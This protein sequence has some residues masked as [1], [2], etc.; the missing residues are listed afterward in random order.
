M[1]SLPLP[2]ALARSVAEEGSPERTEWVSRLP[3]IVGGLVERWALD[4]GA[5]FQPGG[6]VSWV[7]PARDAAGRD[8]VLKVGWTHEEGRDE[9]AGLRVWAGR[10]AVRVFE[11]HVD[12]PTTALLL[13]RCEPGTTCKNAL[14]EPEQ[15]GVVAGLLRRLWREPPPGHPFR[16]LAGMCDWWA[17]EFEADLA[18][19]PDALDPGLARAGVE[20]F[21]GLPR[22]DVPHRLLVTDLHAENVLAAQ[23]EPWLIIDPKPYVGDPAYDVLQHVLNCRDRLLADPRALAGR[24]ADLAGL[25]GER[26]Q[27]WLFARVVQESMNM[28]WLRE[29]V[30]RLAPR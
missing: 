16:T 20:L 28:P 11:T 2:T 8:V 22:E 10:G 18:A 9:A 12:G 3:E 26:V 29:V 19:E 23:R 24:M 4:V 15:D 25:D 6:Q 13:E 30:P 17:D 5:P 7:A 1:Q 14:A 27:L 21:R